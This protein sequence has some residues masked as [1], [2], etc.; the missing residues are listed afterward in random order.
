MSY[1]RELEDWL[2]A[3][4]IRR[5]RPCSDLVEVWKRHFWLM[6]N[7]PEYAAKVERE[8]QERDA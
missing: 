6:E 1:E 3:N 5:R 2:R 7:D 8:A 4:V